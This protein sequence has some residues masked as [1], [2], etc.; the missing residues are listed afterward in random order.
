[1]QRE[2][3]GTKDGGGLMSEKRGSGGGMFEHLVELLEAL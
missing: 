1:M 3:T 2:V